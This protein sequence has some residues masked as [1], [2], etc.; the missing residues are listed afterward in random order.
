M[1]G[2]DIGDIVT[3]HQDW[4]KYYKIVCAHPHSNQEEIGD[5]LI[6]N[7]DLIDYEWLESALK[8][9]KK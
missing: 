9:T 7:P 6:I 8:E 1:D 5:E 3:Q 2:I 4:L